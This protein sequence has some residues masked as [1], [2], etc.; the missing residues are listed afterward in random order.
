[1]R[2]R[3]TWMQILVQPQSS[4]AHGLFPLPHLFMVRIKWD[5][6]GNVILKFLD[7]RC[8]T[9]TWQVKEIE[10]SGLLVFSLVLKEAVGVDCAGGTEKLPGWFNSWKGNSVY[11]T[12]GWICA[13]M[14]LPW[15]GELQSDQAEVLFSVHSSAYRTDCITGREVWTPSGV[16]VQ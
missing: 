12:L 5:I 3:K 11:T 16:Y 14:C 15:G 10:R 4:V 8:M 9:Q 6:P 2:T 7:R 13:G 1:M